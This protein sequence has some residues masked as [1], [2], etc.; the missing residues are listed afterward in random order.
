MP[1]LVNPDVIELSSNDFSRVIP[2]LGHPLLG[3]EAKSIAAGT[4]PGWIFVDSYEAPQ[5]ALIWSEGAEG[6]YLAGSPN[7]GDFA[8]W[9]D[10][11]VREVIVPRAREMGRESF[12][13]SG[14]TPDWD[15][16]IEQAFSGRRLKREIGLI[17]RLKK[18]SVP[19]APSLPT[20]VSLHRLDRLFFSKPPCEGISY[21]EEKIHHFWANLDSFLGVGIGFCASQDSALASVC[22]TGFTTDG[23]HVIDIETLEPN[24]RCGIGYH[25]AY[26]FLTHCI[27][28]GLKPHWGCM[29]ENVPSRALAESLDLSRVL[30]YSL[31]HFPLVG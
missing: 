9:L 4:S 5:L 7:Q 15:A 31:F 11:S 6:Y 28:N 8:Q 17:Y 26:A 23:V 20:G 25:V 13:L 19:A 29:E 22:L 12:E 30:D 2:L 14:C 16:P 10:R 24:R 27:E 3:V 1:T 18:S 21:I